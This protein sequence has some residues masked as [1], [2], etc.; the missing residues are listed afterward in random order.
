M[1][2]FPPLMKIQG[3][4]KFQPKAP[5]TVYH[6]TT[7][8]GFVGI[9][10]EEAMWASHASFLNDESEVSY[11]VEQI[12]QALNWAKSVYAVSHPQHIDFIARVI[13]DAAS[14]GNIMPRFIVAFST[15]RDHLSQWERYSGKFGFSVG[16][17]TRTFLEANSETDGI[18]TRVLYSSRNQQSTL[19]AILRLIFDHASEDVPS[20]SSNEDFQAWAIDRSHRLFLASLCFKHESFRDEHEWRYLVG[21]ENL[22]SKRYSLR[23]GEYGLVPYCSLPIRDSKQKWAIASVTVGTTHYPSEAGYALNLAFQRFDVP[24]RSVKVR[25]STVPLRR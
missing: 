1:F 9:L 16:I 8:S 10:S 7:S 13:Q 22:D 18:F 2:D 5:V 6:Y 25:H 3:F 19:Q 23:S 14:A 17:R 15:K 24:H 4:A 12:S 20:G 11:S 21:V